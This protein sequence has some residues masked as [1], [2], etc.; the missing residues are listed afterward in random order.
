MA[1][2]PVC[3]R[4][5]MSSPQSRLTR[6]DS[7]HQQVARNL[8]NDIEAGVL[9][10]GEALPSTRELAERWG[11]SVFTI[12]EAMKLL[13]DEGLIISKSRSKRVVHAPNQDRGS[14]I[15]LRTPQV[16]MI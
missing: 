11:V 15:R 6:P 10:H 7:L 12:S 14:E 8:R 13:T 16:V 1:R 5:G 2:A 9:R 4:T 3:E